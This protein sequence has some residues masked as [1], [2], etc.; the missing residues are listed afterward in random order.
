MSLTVTDL[1]F[2][3]NTSQHCHYHFRL[4]KGQRVGLIGRNGAGKSTL[5]KLIAGELSAKSGEVSI[6]GSALTRQ[7]QQYLSKLG[8][9]PDQFPDDKGYRVTDFLTLVL[10]CKNISRSLD[11]LLADQGLTQLN[12][13]ELLPLSLQQLSLG[14]KQRL[15]LVQALLS[16]PECLIMDEPLNGL[17]PTQQQQFW[18]ILKQQ[19]NNTCALIASH[20][21]VDLAEHCQRLLFIDDHRLVLDLNL[22]SIKYM[23]VNTSI[24]NNTK[25]N[26]TDALLHD[27]VIGFQQEQNFNQYLLQNDSNI[28]LSGK[29]LTVLTELF[30]YQASGEW[31]W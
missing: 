30:R 1:K 4:T 28:L 26:E 10:A 31:Q 21:L 25:I 18:Q 12:I 14:Q 20:H 11:D 13:G 15:S 27:K 3:Y 17:D 2:H 24:I 23:A 22:D 19:T 7:P 5:L 8:Y 16:Q 6:N 29:T 9:V